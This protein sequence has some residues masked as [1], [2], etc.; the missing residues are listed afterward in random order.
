M[1]K[2][3]VL[4]LVA[5]ALAQIQDPDSRM[6]QPPEPDAVPG[7]A[8]TG[9]SQGEHYRTLKA[10]SI[11]SRSL[12]DRNYCVSDSLLAEWSPQTHSEF[13][14]ADF[15]NAFALYR[16]LVPGILLGGGL[17]GSA[18]G[19]YRSMDGLKRW[20]NESDR[21]RLSLR[22]IARPGNDDLLSLNLGFQSNGNRTPERAPRNQGFFYECRGTALLPFDA[23]R[24]Y[25]AS[26]VEMA[27]WVEDNRFH[28]TRLELGGRKAVG[29]SAAFSASGAYSRI[30]DASYFI[31]PTL[32]SD[33]FAAFKFVHQPAWGRESLFLSMAE[34]RFD[35]PDAPERD[36]RERSW[37]L[38]WAPEWSLKRFR[39][40]GAA[41]RTAG[42][43]DFAYAEKTDPRPTADRLV[44]ARAQLFNEQSLEYL[45]S[46]RLSMDYFRG[47]RIAFSSL[48]NMRRYDYPYRFT[49]PDGR[50]TDN[51]DSRDLL[52]DNDTF[53]VEF[54]ALDSGLLAL[55]RSSRLINYL[56][57][58]RSKDNRLGTTWQLCLT[59]AL[60]RPGII[61]SRASAILSVNEDSLHYRLSRS[62]G[63]RFFRRRE[64]W[65]FS[66]V[67]AVP[68]FRKEEDSLIVTLSYGFEEDGLL[69]NETG[70]RVFVPQKLYRESGFNF[71][72]EKGFL[73]RY[74]LTAGLILSRTR[75]LVSGGDGFENAELSTAREGYLRANGRFG[76]AQA[77]LS[78]RK[79]QSFFDHAAVRNYLTLALEMRTEF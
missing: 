45:L 9:F 5:A 78:I 28:R 20:E 35:Y 14:Q 73:G 1:D 69:E 40:G 22:G 17:S 36:R 76:R 56:D 39:L 29:G 54:P 21:A 79:I 64:V 19:L 11:L 6:P 47:R 57:S 15:S 16:R 52:I 24:E 3:L 70:T 51:P 65:L 58:R 44:V 49:D 71:R 55:S 2:F 48:R 46:T 42:S 77:S 7:F 34:N 72:I 62:A 50:L 10:L 53:S 38:A 25:R 63:N 66:D 18:K 33:R 8:S 12:P 74:S 32:R 37:T 60:R 68:G 41:A 43:A 61:H 4:A 23:V 31:E 30:N 59:H 26:F 13:T 27:D 75:G 67:D